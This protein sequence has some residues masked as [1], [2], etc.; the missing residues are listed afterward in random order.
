MANFFL[1]P[2]YSIPPF[3]T[4]TFP[5]T[6]STFQE[7]SKF[8][9][10]A[11]RTYITPDD[12]NNAFK[13]RNVEPVY[14]LC[15]SSDP[16]RFTKAAGHADIVYAEDPVVPLSSIVEAPLPPL[17]WEAGVTVH[18]MAVNGKQPAIP[19]NMPLVPLTHRD[20]RQ[21]TEKTRKALP[22]LTVKPAEIATTTTGAEAEA[23]AT[24]GTATQ[25]GTGTV[26]E[27]VLVRAPLKHVVSKELHLYYNKVV[28]ALETAA[29]PPASASTELLAVLASLRIDAGLQPLAPYFAH[30]LAEKVGVYLPSAPRLSL[31]LRAAVS[32]GSNPSLDLGPYL[33]EIMPAVLTC[34]LAHS[35]GESTS[36]EVDGK[37]KKKK[38]KND[39]SGDITSFDSDAFH[40]TVREEAA[41]A[42]A[43][44][45]TTYP[46]A[47]PRVQRQLL[48]SL[49][50]PTSSL[51]CRYGAVLGLEAQGSRVV[52]SLLL[53]NLIPA[54]V[55][56]KEDLSGKK[57][58][59]N[60]KSAMKVRGALLAA[61]GYCVYLSGVCAAWN[62]HAAAVGG[63]KAG[64]RQREEGEEKEEAG[65]GGK[66]KKPAAKKK[67]AKTQQPKIANMSR[68]EA[69]AVIAGNASRPPSA[70]AAAAAAAASGNASLR[71]PRGG[72]KAG[73]AGT[74]TTT[75]GNKKNNNDASS[76][77]HL[78]E[79]FG[80]EEEQDA[81]TAAALAA[82]GQNS[83]KK[84]LTIA[85]N[86]RPTN[87]DN[88]A[89]TI[90]TGGGTK[91]GTSTI[92]AIVPAPGLLLENL[93]RINYLTEAWRED[94]PV[95]RLH[96]AMGELFGDDIA[97][98]ER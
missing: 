81:T 42:A 90:T 11:K 52:R 97:P 45:C 30:Y 96:Q 32:L 12:I 24:A 29:P 70:A 25:H 89:V 69:E 10:H 59:Q 67:G 60:L 22:A 80:D 17:P 39:A 88:A 54:V 91:D 93:P 92:T 21:R 53:P 34:L 23:A 48:S 83:L 19:E 77:I 71:R 44:L 36:E 84:V 75:N 13:L 58:E 26:E 50:S 31:L 14:G 76:P 98:Y 2:V 73:I 15:S 65:A 20:K 61:S 49:T 82:A 57:G 63:K 40:W 94:F 56:L 66:R 87:K 86:M 72:K 1:L 78:S 46:D 68:S 18:W 55:A 38:E 47:A 51:P 95:E 41:R 79:I 35:V 16:A 3:D 28:T 27:G 37:Q 62:T 43:A 9:R 33:H 4:L 74:T 85:G 64:N 6:F 5:T 7:A 8:A